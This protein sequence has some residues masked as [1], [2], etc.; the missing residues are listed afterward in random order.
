MISL[1]KLHCRIVSLSKAGPSSCLQNKSSAFFMWYGSARLSTRSMYSSI[2]K[3]EPDSATSFRKIANPAA[4]PW[5][6]SRNARNDSG[7]IGNTSS[8]M[9]QGVGTS[10]AGWSCANFFASAACCLLML[11][12]I[13]NLLCH[14]CLDCSLKAFHSATSSALLLWSPCFLFCATK[15]IN[16]F[17]FDAAAWRHLAGTSSSWL[18]W[19][20]LAG[21]GPNS[22]LHAARSFFWHWQPVGCCLSMGLQHHHLQ[23][24]SAQHVIALPSKRPAWGS[25][26]S[27]QLLVGNKPVEHPRPKWAD[28]FATV[29]PT[30]GR[31]SMETHPVA[32]ASSCRG[33]LEKRQGGGEQ[34]S[35]EELK[36]EPSIAISLR[37]RVAEYF[38]QSFWNGLTVAHPG[39]KRRLESLLNSPSLHSTDHPKP[40][41]ETAEPAAWRPGSGVDDA[42]PPKTPQGLCGAFASSSFPPDG[43]EHG[44]SSPL[45]LH[46][47]TQSN[48]PWSVPWIGRGCMS[49][50]SW[51]WQTCPARTPRLSLSFG[52]GDVGKLQLRPL[53]LQWV[54]H[55]QHPCPAGLKNAVWSRGDACQNPKANNSSKQQ[56][57]RC[58]EMLA[59]NFRLADGREEPKNLR[60]QETIHSIAW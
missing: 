56:N 39:A 4:L 37:R 36:T 49:A 23:V 32:L 48:R 20:P 29:E 40:C 57:F 7:L 25:Q 50:T 28:A 21:H 1:A 16:S 43:L 19:A 26:A 45:C 54:H 24:A 33:T 38:L 51:R 41:S 52:T 3:L 12:L 2:S 46:S 14:H 60:E 5:K 42:P 13:L 18:P 53:P 35:M 34:N 22:G 10:G 31:G 9:S 27:A 55:S 30:K 17:L 59:F 44:Q 11:E 8:P 6:P 47:P 15:K 58:S